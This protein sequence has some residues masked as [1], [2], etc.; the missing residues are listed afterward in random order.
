MGLTH[1]ACRFTNRSSL[2]HVKGNTLFNLCFLTCK[3]LFLPLLCVS[4][5]FPSHSLDCD[6]LWSTGETETMRRFDKLPHSIGFHLRGN[7]CATIVEELGCSLS[8]ICSLLQLVYVDSMF[9]GRAR[10]EKLY[11]RALPFCYCA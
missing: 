10:Q 4:F 8:N 11:T 1:A 2:S 9:P 3:H 7:L 6:L 5:A